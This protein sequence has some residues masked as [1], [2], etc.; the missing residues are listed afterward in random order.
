MKW[1]H[2]IARQFYYSLPSLCEMT[3]AANFQ[4]IIAFI[5]TFSDWLLMEKRNALIG[6]SIKS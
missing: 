6:L 4:L 5:K 1:Y 2:G 3:S